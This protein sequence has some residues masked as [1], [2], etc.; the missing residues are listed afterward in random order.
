MKLFSL[1]FGF[2]FKCQSVQKLYVV[3]TGYSIKFDFVREVVPVNAK[4]LTLLKSGLKIFYFLFVP[5]QKITMGN[6]RTLT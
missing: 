2:F 1:L 6:Q 3:D 4:K 5:T